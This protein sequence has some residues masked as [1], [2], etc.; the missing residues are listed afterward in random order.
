[1]I[2]YFALYQLFL[3]VFS[4]IISNLLLYYSK[5]SNLENHNLCLSIYLYLISGKAS[6]FLSFLMNI[7]IV[8]NNFFFQGILF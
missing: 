1:M 2:N 4:T 5:F 3:L 7:V 6:F 8:F